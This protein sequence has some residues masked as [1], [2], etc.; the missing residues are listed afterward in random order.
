MA[1][2]ILYFI[3]IGEAGFVDSNSVFCMFRKN[4]KYR[5]CI[6][7]QTYAGNPSSLE[8]ALSNQKFRFVKA[9][10][11]DKKTMDELFN[12]ERPDSLLIWYLDNKEWQETIENIIKR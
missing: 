3:A 9:D 7:K 2:Q 5:I 4:P 1:N 11:C 10:I 12:K 8:P 6:N